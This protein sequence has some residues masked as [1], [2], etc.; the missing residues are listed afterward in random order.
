MKKYCFLAASFLL[1]AVVSGCA[2][3]DD[4]VTLKSPTDGVFYTVETSHN[5]GP[6]S[7]D[8]RV[9]AHLER[10]GKTRKIL[11]LAGGDLTVERI[12]WTSPHEG[13][14]CLQGGITDTFRN[15]V[16]LILDDKI[17][18]TMHHHLQEHC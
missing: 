2:K 1:T 9:Y 10:N 7:D 12:I 4:V 11:V 3:P 18:E 14:F 13:T 17:S 15:E 8:T 5:S 16:T 6:V